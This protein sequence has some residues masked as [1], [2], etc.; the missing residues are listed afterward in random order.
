MP[1]KTLTILGSSLIGWLMGAALIWGLH[2]S[3]NKLDRPDL[4]DERWA[5]AALFCALGAWIGIIL[6]K[7]I[8]L[9]ARLDLSRHQRTLLGLPHFFGSLALMGVLLKGGWSLGLITRER[10]PLALCLL[11]LMVAWLWCRHDT[12]YEEWRQSR[13]LEDRPESAEEELEKLV[14]A[15]EADGWT[16]EMITEYRR[17]H[18][19]SRQRDSDS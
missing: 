5:T 1:N 15:F 7:A 2:S 18:R 14:R 13:T 6:V 12:A 3:E 8:P 9:E 16:P 11:P 4:A 19:L 17:A 10:L